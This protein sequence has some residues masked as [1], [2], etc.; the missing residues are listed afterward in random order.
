MLHITEKSKENEWEIILAITRNDG[1]PIKIIQNLKA[2]LIN[3][4]KKQKQTQKQQQQQQETKIPKIK[5]IAVTYFSP[6]VRQVTKLFKQ[7]DLKIA[8]HATNTIHQQLTEKQTHKDPSGI[9]KLKCNTCGKVYVGQ[10]GRTIGVRLKERIRHV[11]SNNP[12]SA[13]ATHILE[14]RHEYGTKENTLQLLKAC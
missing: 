7:T 12:T 8:F 11:R 5:W 4:E 6:L 10:C 1:Y 13:Y 2:K 14:N 9:Y 3:K